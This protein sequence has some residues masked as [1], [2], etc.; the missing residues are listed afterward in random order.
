MAEEK[1][2]P[3][4]ATPPGPPAGQKAAESAALSNLSDANGESGS[5]TATNT[6]ALGAALSNLSVAGSGAAT[7]TQQ[8]KAA[9]AP[10]K[11]VKIDA[12]DVTFLVDNLEVTKAKATSMLRAA[13]GS[14]DKA[15]EDFVLPASMKTS[16]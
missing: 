9:D 1:P 8:A 13:D 11:K 3:A 10:A 2:L 14:K 15:L 12:A 5:S 4:E 16:A 6:A 7:T